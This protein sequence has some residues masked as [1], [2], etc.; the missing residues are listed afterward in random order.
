MKK[1]TSILLG[2]TLVLGTAA[3]AADE[4]HADKSVDKTATT[5]KKAKKAKKADAAADAKKHDEKK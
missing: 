3:F 1:I 2:M 5:E 4:K